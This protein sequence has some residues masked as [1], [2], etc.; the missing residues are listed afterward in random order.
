[1]RDLY[2]T[3]TNEVRI[4]A[5][6]E[7]T[8]PVLDQ[9]QV[10][11]IFAAMDSAG[12]LHRLVDTSGYITE[13]NS[14]SIKNN[15]TYNSYATRAD[16]YYWD[17]AG[18]VTSADS[19]LPIASIVGAP[20]V[21]TADGAGNIGA[22]ADVIATGGVGVTWD[23]WAICQVSTTGSYTTKWCQDPTGTPAPTA[24]DYHTAGHIAYM[25]AGYPYILRMVA[26]ATN[27]AIGYDT[28]VNGNWPNGASMYI[29]GWKRDIE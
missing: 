27:L 6:Y 4:D 21:I 29:T 19:W 24:P 10:N 23:V 28:G 9:E 5:E 20:T 1:M 7:D 17:A 8:R 15:M 2:V 3:P 22:A 11:V 12:L 25:V 18:A 14:T 26:T 13:A 16:P